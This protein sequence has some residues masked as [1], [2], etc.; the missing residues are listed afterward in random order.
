[1]KLHSLRIAGFRGFNDEQTL[2]LEG[3][4]VIYCGPN[5]AGK[6]SIGEALEWLM[7]GSTLKRSRGDE[8]SKRE[9]AESYRNAHYAGPKRPFVEAEITDASGTK[10]VIRRELLDDETSILTVDGKPFAALSQFGIGTVHDRPM[11]LQHTLQDF[12]FMKPKTRYEVL[13]AM[14]GLES[15]I[16]FRNAVEQA[17]NDLA[18]RLPA[19]ITDAQR[20]ATS[21]IRSFGSEPL[22]KPVASAVEQGNLQEAHRHLQQVALGRV[23]AGTAE[24]QLEQ[25]LEATKAAKQRAQLDW[26]RFSLNPVPSPDLHPAM[27]ELQTLRELMNGFHEEVKA[28][29]DA[30]V[31]SGNERQLDPKLREFI[32]LG[33]QIR[34]ADGRRCPFCLEETLTTEKLARLERAVELV[35]EAR[36]SL[37]KAQGALRAI[38]TGFQRHSE[39]LS[40]LAPTLPS[41]RELDVVTELAADA[42]GSASGYR[43]ACGSVR[44]QLTAL[45]A[46]RDTLNETLRA[47]SDGISRGASPEKE[48]ETLQEAFRG[49][50]E[51]AKGLPAVANAYAATY[52]SLDPHIKGKLAS[53]QEV[54]FL[55]LLSDG[56]GGWGDI[57]LAYQA[58]SMAELLQDVIRRTRGF[59]ENKQKQILGVRDKEIRA[60]YDLMNPGVQVGYDGIVPSTDSLELR[61]RSFTKTIM[62]APN[63]SASQLNCVGLAVHLACATRGASPHRMLLFDDP[64]QS[65]DDEHTESFKKTIVKDLLDRGLQVIVLTHMDN[66]AE[67][68]EKLYRSAVDTVL[69]RMHS[70][71]RSG[72]SVIWKGPEIRSLLEEVRRNK[73]SEN[74]GFRK[75][76]VQALRQ[77]VER[78]VKDLYT[79]ETGKAVSKR[80]RDKNWTE[81][82]NLLRQVK[83]FDPKDEARLEDIIV[84]RV[85]SSTLMGVFPQE[86]HHQH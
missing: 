82:K 66:F 37:A 85:N 5:G 68:M 45:A 19:K 74:E 1:M 41:D 57:E 73:D 33:L 31:S 9:Y 42:P 13:S 17:K 65:M 16:A 70:Y 59:I 36:P 39:A 27:R 8:I 44:G 29:V 38:Q 50:D 81:L 40:R 22:L 46:A 52:A 69:Y 15:L 76:A 28:T 30:I 71:S 14:L 43:E 35:P 56:L 47:T 60:W 4:L 72:P 23:P 26:G 64:I 83:Q 11:I 32:S 24:P 75:Q 3:Q 80:F 53:V 49:Y 58:D 61:A 54:R 62:A 2:D 6:T 12:I 21:L 25:A 48:Y 20:R 7:Y 63:L 67:D 51:S 86:F 79:A 78:F 77:F 18:R 34:G 10:R 84:S 55:S